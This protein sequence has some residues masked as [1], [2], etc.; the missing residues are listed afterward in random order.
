MDCHIRRKRLKG[1]IRLGRHK[2]KLIS[3]AVR[4]RNVVKSGEEADWYMAS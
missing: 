4:R 3:Y 2:K 1:V